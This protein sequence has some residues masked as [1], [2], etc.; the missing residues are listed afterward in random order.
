MPEQWPSEFICPVCKNPLDKAVYVRCCGAVTCEHCINENE[1]GECPLCEDIWEGTL[2]D[3][4]MRAVLLSIQRDWFYLEQDGPP[5]MK[6]LTMS[7]IDE[8]EDASPLKALPAPP[9]ADLPLEKIAGDDADE[10]SGADAGGSSE[11]P[12]AG[13]GG[14]LGIP[15]PISG[16]SPENR[17][18]PGINTARLLG[19]IKDDSGVTSPE[20]PR[21]KAA[22][23]K[24]Q[25]LSASAALAARYAAENA[26]KKMKKKQLKANASTASTTAQ[27]GGTTSASTA[28]TENV[29]GIGDE[30]ATTEPKRPENQ[31]AFPL[32]DETASTEASK[33]VKAGETDVSPQNSAEK[34]T[35]QNAASSTS[36]VPMHQQSAPLVDKNDPP[37][38]AASSSSSIAVPK[39]QVVG[40]VVGAATALGKTPSPVSSPPPVIIPGACVVPVASLVGF[41]PAAAS[42]STSSAADNSAVA[43]VTKAIPLVLGG[44]ST[45]TSITAGGA[46]ISSA[47]TLS[48]PSKMNKDPSAKSAEGTAGVVV[49]GNTSSASSSSGSHA[50]IATRSASSI[51]T[52]AATSSS[53]STGAATRGAVIADS[54]AGAA[55]SSNA[56]TSSSA[57]G[58]QGAA[59]KKSSKIQIIDGVEYLKTKSGLVP[60]S[61]Y[62]QAWAK[63]GGPPKKKQKRGEQDGP[64][65]ERK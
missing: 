6:E 32:I 7:P 44:V 25:F 20:Q 5:L 64:P 47:K 33:A 24:T 57:P 35:V 26:K 34:T 11:S 9:L 36:A 31:E 39:I 54:G 42:S 2:P 61:V 19:G 37:V 27:Q 29:A 3:Q 28:N 8:E 15:D 10:N 63:H 52:T 14:L 46:S 50:A 21:V 40:S 12:E 38:A 4:L 16:F 30:I 56:V 51:P 55:S 62:E 59:K 49:A 43:S 45:C 1:E 23:P 60:R 22:P 41:S 17:T 65:V 58:D 13:A 53:S 18:G 48:G